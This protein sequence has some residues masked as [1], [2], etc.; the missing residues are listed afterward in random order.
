MIQKT[1]V[2][3]KPDGVQRALIGKILTRFE[4]AGLKIVAMKMKWIDDKFAL[5]H[6]TEDIVK[7]R[8]EIVRKK[9]IEFIKSGPVLAMVLEGVNAIEI[10]R[11]MAG[12]TEPRKASLGTIRGDF[13]HVSYHYAAGKNIAVKNIIH[14]S[15]DEKDAEYEIKLWFSK[16]EMHDYETVHDAHIFE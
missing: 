12:D 2:L 4:D 9:L 10:V 6:Y 13:C 11:K 3:I 7:R 5:K 14:A 8:G 15:S 16:D 1:L